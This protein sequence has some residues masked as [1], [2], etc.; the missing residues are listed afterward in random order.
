[1]FLYPVYLMCRSMGI[2][3]TLVGNSHLACIA[4][5]PHMIH[6]LRTMV[7]CVI[8]F[9]P[10]EA[11]PPFL[12]AVV[13]VWSDRVV[14]EPLRLLMPSIKIAGCHKEKPK[15]NR[16][17][18]FWGF[19]FSSSALLLPRAI[20]VQLQTEPVSLPCEMVLE[21]NGRELC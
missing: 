21:A 17:V 18:C 10:S 11:I 14:L 15:T 6:G 20:D 4:A 9:P 19:L 1:M 2:S 8:I 16:C 3:K 5:P 13:K 7:L 12:S